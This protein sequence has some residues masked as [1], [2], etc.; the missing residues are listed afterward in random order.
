MDN[1]FKNKAYKVLELFIEHPHKE[2]YI[3]EVARELKLSHAIVIKYIKELNKAKLM[4]KNSKSLYPVYSAN[5]G[6]TRFLFYKRNHILFKIINSGLIDYLWKKTLAE[7][8]IL[9][10]SCA[11]GDFT[12][13]SDIDIFIE[14]KEIKLDLSKYEKML[15]RKINLLFEPDIDGLSKGL[16]Y[17]IVKG[18][19]LYGSLKIE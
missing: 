12:E 4:K 6:N 1:I 9:F 18:I 15:K 3:R 19:T 13:K 11:T 10:G 14:T 2:F 7:A 17:N 16:K 8:I 5:Y